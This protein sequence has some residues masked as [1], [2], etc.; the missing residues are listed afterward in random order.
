M[1]D[2]EIA[3]I[4]AGSALAGSIVTGWFTRS[5]GHRQ[6][7][8]ARHAGNRQAD[9]LLHTVQATLDEQRRSQAE[10]RRR[11][12]YVGLLQAAEKI[13]L[14]GQ[15]GAEERAALLRASTLVSLEGPNAVALAGLQLAACANQF[16]LDSPV[17]E[18]LSQRFLTVRQAFEQA[19]RRSLNSHS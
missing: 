7:D 6:A 15:R 5:A 3:L 12:A 19:A 17:S 18:E 16:S 11:Q 14:L 13:A 4:A 9:A 10:E 1:N 8:A 2:L